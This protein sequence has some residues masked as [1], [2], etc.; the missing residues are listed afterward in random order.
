MND[1]CP[2]CKRQCEPGE[3]TWVHDAY[4]IPYM[5]VCDDCYGPVKHRISAWRLDPGYAG[6][7]L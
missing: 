7:R 3:R 4:G 2:G 5:K 6:E 1:E